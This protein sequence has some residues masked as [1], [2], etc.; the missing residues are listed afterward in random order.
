VTEL[1][2]TLEAILFV[3]EEPIPLT[4]LAQITERPKDEVEQTLEGLAA[5]LD[6]G[7]RGVVLR[8]AAGGWRMYTH[9]DAAAYVERFVLSSQQP[10][11]TQAALETLAI[12]A[13]KQPVTR[14]QVAQ[15]RGVDSDGVIG[16]LQ[17]RGLVEEVGQDPGP[18]QASLFGTT[19]R[20]MERLGLRDL[21]E[22]PPIAHLLPPES[23]ANDLE[24]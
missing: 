9:P 7:G 22:L 6:S 4:V 12:V 16:T 14:Q 19:R 23:A 8:E 18:G 1:S 10:R 2:L 3:A 21:T 5:E 24:P 11:L 13:Y 20:F 15:I 17:V